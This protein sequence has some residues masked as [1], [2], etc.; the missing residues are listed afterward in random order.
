MHSKIMVCDD[1]KATVGSTNIDP[2]S[3]LLDMEINA[4]VESI[5]YAKEIKKI[6]LADEKESELITPKKWSERPICQRVEERLARL[7]SAQL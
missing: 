2:R 5:E 1:C 6:F 3:Y 7:F 4:F